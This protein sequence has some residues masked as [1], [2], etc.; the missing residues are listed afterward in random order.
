MAASKEFRFKR[1]VLGHKH[2]FGCTSIQTSG[3][4]MA[5]AEKDDLKLMLLTIYVLTVYNMVIR[6]RVNVLFH[7]ICEGR[8]V[9]IT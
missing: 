4:N 5:Y 8:F 2:K 9:K 7:A 3:V 6:I 1:G